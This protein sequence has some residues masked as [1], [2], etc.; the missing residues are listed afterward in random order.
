M[1]LGYVGVFFMLW[2]LVI[3]MVVLWLI[4]W[5]VSMVIMCVLLLVLWEWILIEFL[6]VRWCIWFVFCRFMV[7]VMLWCFMKEELFLVVVFI[8]L[9]LNWLNRECCSMVVLEWCSVVV[10]LIFWFR[11]LDLRCVFCSLLRVVFLEERLSF[12]CCV[13]KIM[14]WIFSLILFV[15]LLCGFLLDCLRLSF[16]DCFSCCKI[17]K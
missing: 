17:L 4:V 15:G 14:C 13:M 9:F 1:K 11:F 10:V 5:F 12:G 7:I 3:W 8:F 2:F 6:I 16:L